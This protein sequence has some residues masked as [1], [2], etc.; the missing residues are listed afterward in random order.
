[1]FNL[2][3]AADKKKY[4]LFSKKNKV[5]GKLSIKCFQQG[6]LFYNEE[7]LKSYEFTDIN[8]YLI[9]KKNGRIA[10][11]PKRSCIIEELNK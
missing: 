7:N 1:M 6:I 4:S 8:T 9:T 3:M 10:L 11:L 2:S 5:S